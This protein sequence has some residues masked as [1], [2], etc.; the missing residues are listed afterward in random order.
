MPDF[1]AEQ[2]SY[3]LAHDGDQVFIPGFVGAGEAFGTGQPHL[4]A[5][6]T[7]DALAAR[8]AELKAPDPDLA[9]AAIGSIAT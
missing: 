9:L 8:L 6:A 1:Y 5:F 3:F 7:R 4:E 2:D